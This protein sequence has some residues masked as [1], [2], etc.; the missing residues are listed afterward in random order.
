MNEKI[1]KYT[2]EQVKKVLK[3]YALPISNH[4]PEYHLIHIEKKLDELLS[5]TKS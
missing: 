5:N 1:D 2:I 4:F 3:D